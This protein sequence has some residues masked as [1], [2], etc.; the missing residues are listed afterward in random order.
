M[1]ANPLPLMS[2]PGDTANTLGC[3]CGMR[4]P[5]AFS[6]SWESLDEAP[7]PKSPERDEARHWM[8]RLLTFDPGAVED[9]LTAFPKM[10]RQQ[11]R[12]LLRNI[13]KKGSASAKAGK[14]LETLIRDHLNLTP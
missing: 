1:R 10:E 3:S 9:L 11:V 6:V 12:Q 13:Q 8:D 5:T 2:R 7:R 4:I 14:A